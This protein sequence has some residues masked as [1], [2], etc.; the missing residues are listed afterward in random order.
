MISRHTG[1][2]E[3]GEPWAV[4]VTVAAA[5]VSREG[6][7]PLAAELRARLAAWFA[8][9]WSYGELPAAPALIAAHIAVRAAEMLREL[10]KPFPAESWITRVRI[11]YGDDVAEWFAG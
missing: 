10:A 11:T 9:R 3:Q 6:T 7:V 8:G 1:T 2:A 5:D 4:E